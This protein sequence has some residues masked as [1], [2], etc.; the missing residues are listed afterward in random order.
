[1]CASVAVN[2][3]E[4]V[5]VQVNTFGNDIILAEACRDDVSKLC[6]KV[7]AGH[8]ALHDCLREHR[9][10]LSAK[11]RKEEFRLE[12][13][14]SSNFELRTS[15]MRVRARARDPAAVDA[16]AQDLA[17]RAV[18]AGVCGGTRDVLRE[19]PGRRRARV[20][21]PRH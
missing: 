10:K 18:H 15:F 2:T 13:E 4:S 19:R 16:R 21:L 1:M 6:S 8:G 3:S 11:C 9:Q 12:I 17:T 14:E 20:P 5:R 7:Q